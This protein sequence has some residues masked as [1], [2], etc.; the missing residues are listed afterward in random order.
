MKSLIKRGS[1]VLLALVLVLTLVL[2]VNTQVQ[3]AYADD[4]NWGAFPVDISTADTVK[5]GNEVTFDVKITNTINK[6]I[7]VSLHNIYYREFDNS[8]TYPGETFGEFSGDGLQ[9]SDEEYDVS[10]TIG[11]G[12]TVPLTLKGTIPATWND[13]SEVCIVVDAFDQGYMGQ[14]DYYGTGGSEPPI[15][16]EKAENTLWVKGKT[17][18]VSYSKVKKAA[19]ALAITKVISFTDKGQGTKTY[20]KVSGNSKITINKST[21]KVTIKK[22][23]KK[24]TYAVK[25]K[26]KAAG[27][28]DY[29]AA[30]M[31]VTFKIKVK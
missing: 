28:E 25:I 10:I 26:V 4:V 9:V 1:A 30:I 27:N 31:T 22:G 18:A 17:A 8:D 12:K 6:T 7:K 14:G 5:P 19:Q 3:S 13:R 29:G 2:A 11:A 20:T 16:Y 23:L 21:G 24:G 15:S